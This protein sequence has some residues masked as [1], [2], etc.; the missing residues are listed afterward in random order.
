M[1]IVARP[2]AENRADEGDV[3]VAAGGAI[4]VLAK[5]TVADD[6][7]LGFTV[8]AADFLEG[9]YEGGEAVSRVESSEEENYGNIGAKSG[10][11]GNVR[12]EDIGIDSIRD[13]RPIGLEVSIER[14]RRGVRDGDRRVELIESLLE[15]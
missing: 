6:N 4:V 14:D 7:E 15:L 8:S 2:L 3:G 5:R 12:V 10:W 1:R 11:A 9:F 13:N